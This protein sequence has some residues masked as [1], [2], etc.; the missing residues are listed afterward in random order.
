[1][2]RHA[3]RP[4]SFARARDRRRRACERPADGRAP[5]D[6]ELATTTSRCSACRAPDSSRDRRAGANCRPRCTPTALPPRARPR[7]AGHAMGRA[8]QRGASAPEG[9]VDARQPTCASCG[10]MPCGPDDA[11]VA[12]PS[13][14]ARCIGAR[15]ST[16]RRPTSAVKTL[17]AEV[18]AQENAIREQVRGASTS[19]AM[20]KRRRA[21]ARVD[22]PGPLSCRNRT[23]ARGSGG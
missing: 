1:M 19:G 2:H 21:A 18:T 23:P 3:H 11:P 13:W 16:K 22:V 15:R 4:S 12:P 5:S 7:S 8:R 6:H 14:H 17:D 9:S 20:H 10:A